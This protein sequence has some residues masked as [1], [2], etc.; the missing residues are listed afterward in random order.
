MV[1]RGSCVC[2]ICTV[3]EV[4][5]FLGCSSAGDFC[6]RHRHAPASHGR[7]VALLQEI[8]L[9]KEDL[10]GLVVDSYSRLRPKWLVPRW[11]GRQSMAKHVRR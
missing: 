6:Q 9:H 2:F 1:V 8:F 10:L 3:V 5:F 11:R 7:R 4:V